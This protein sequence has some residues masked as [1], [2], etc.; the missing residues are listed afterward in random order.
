M[1]FL[2][3]L[4][5]ASTVLLPIAATVQGAETRGAE[6]RPT[7]MATPRLGLSGI[8]YAPYQRGQ[9]P[10]RG[11]APTAEQVARDVALMAPHCRGLRTYAASNGS[12][13]VPPAAAREGLRVVQGAWISHEPAWNAAELD[14]LV[15]LS[16]NHPGAVTRLLV[17]NEAIWRAD[18]RPDE[19]AAMM[20]QARARTGLPVS[21]SEPWHVWLKTP[22]LAEAADFLAVHLLPYWD[23]V[24]AEQAPAYLLGRIEELRRAYP[25]KPVVVTEIGWPRQGPVR[26]GAVP[27]PGNQELFLDLWRDA[28]RGT[29]LEWYWLEGFDQPWKDVEEAG[30]GG[31]WGLWHAD[32]G[33]AVRQLRN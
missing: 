23:G 32:R 30:L 22:A 9:D 5:M 11:D 20:A 1:R 14:R 12:Q 6:T 18:V 16:R 28:T 4:V 13:H 7:E 31:H 26:G 15:A 8:S 24:P 29:D 17:G 25:G 27:S 21:T 10:N 19:L 3:S 33:P 2:R